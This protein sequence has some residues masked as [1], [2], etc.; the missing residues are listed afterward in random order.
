VDL[1]TPLLL[2]GVFKKKLAIQVPG[3]ITERTFDSSSTL[4][5]ESFDSTSTW[6][7]LDDVW[8]L[9]CTMFEDLNLP[10]HGVLLNPLWT[11]DYNTTSC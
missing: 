7:I 9:P 3:V 4:L 8:E 2:L 11:M 1:C 5:F 10:F 6:K